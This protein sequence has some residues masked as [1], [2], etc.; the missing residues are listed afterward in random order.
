MRRLEDDIAPTLKQLMEQTKSL[1]Q[2]A[3][4]DR[5]L[6]ARWATK[7][8]YALVFTSLKSVNPSVEHAR[9]LKDDPKR[10]PNGVIVFAAQV[11][12]GYPTQGHVTSEWLGCRE[13]SESLDFAGPKIRQ[14]YKCGIRFKALNL[15]VAYWP[16]P[17]WVLSPIRGMH[18]LVFPTNAPLVWREPTA[19]TALE[20]IPPAYKDGG[21][22]ALML[23]ELGLA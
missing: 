4:R 18:Y 22:H 10:L 17:R 14:S 8:A 23:W 1:E 2:L 15:Y 6:V 3:D 16:D 7:T 12:D 19:C 21:P 13:G 5:F 20:R 11:S 9:A